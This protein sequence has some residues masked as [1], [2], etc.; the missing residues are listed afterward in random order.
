MNL[1]RDGI[2]DESVQMTEQVVKLTVDGVTSNYPVY[3]VR[4]DKLFYNDQNDR[5]ATWISQYKAEH[6][7]DS[8]SRED[9]KKY[10]DVIQSFIEKSNPDKMKT[11]QENINLYGQQHHGVVLNDGRII[12]GNRRYTCLRNLSSS[13]DNFNYFE[14]VILERDYDKSAKQIKMLELQLQI[15]SEERVDYDP[16]DRLVGLYRDIIE[17]GLL[18]EEEYARSTNQKTSV[19]KKELEIAKLVVEFLDAIKAPKQYYLARELE[20][21]GPIRELHAALSSISDEDKQQAVKY[22]A[23]TN[24]LMRPDGSMTPFIRKLKGIS[25]SVYL[26]EFIDKE[27]DICETTLDNLP[28]AGKVNS[29]VIAKIRTDDKTKEDLKRIMTVVDNKV[30]VKETRD[31]PNQMVKS[32]IDSLKAIDVEIIK[33][34][35]DEQIEDMKANLEMLEEVLNEVKE[36]VNV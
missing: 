21:D 17:N 31:K 19:V 16:I 15:G 30:K 7:E 3:R 8:L 13:S 23:F 18:T 27:E 14:T 10:N 24:L 35:T 32:A 34:L 9:A 36:S 26:D 25:K 5:I 28:D 6:G 12:D 29:E 20:I 2:A 22:I 11:T 4:L 1:L 33:R